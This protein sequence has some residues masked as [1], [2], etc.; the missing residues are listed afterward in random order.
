MCLALSRDE[1]LLGLSSLL[2]GLRRRLR[3]GGISELDAVD[4]A[5]LRLD[6]VSLSPLRMPVFAGG[7]LGLLALGEPDLGEEG[8]VTCAFAPSSRECVPSGL[9]QGLLGC[10]FVLAAKKRAL[11]SF[12]A[13]KVAL[14]PLALPLPFVRSLAACF[15]MI[16]RASSRTC[17][18][19]E[20]ASSPMVTYLAGVVQMWR[21]K[22]SLMW[23]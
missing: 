21:K 22:L 14:P 9:F 1:R 4:G 17:T 18:W 8:D 5:S 19:P 3:L 16:L 23:W 20:S 12:A 15:V 6:L 2:L 11:A 7:E 13:S 10:I